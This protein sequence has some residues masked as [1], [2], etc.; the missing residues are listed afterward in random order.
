MFCSK[1][2]LMTAV[3]LTA[4]ATM[5]PTVSS[6][7]MITANDLHD[8]FIGNGAN[9]NGTIVVGDKVFDFNGL[10]STFSSVGSGG[11]TGPTDSQIF[12]SGEFANTSAPGIVFQSAFW[13]VSNGGGIDT[14]FSFNVSA[15][16]KLIDD[17]ALNLNTFGVRNGGAIQIAETIRDGSTVVGSLLASNLTPTDH[18]FFTDLHQSLLV[19]KDV[20]L[21]SIS[22]DAGNSQAFISDFDQ[23]FSEQPEP[24]GVILMGL[25]VLGMVGYRWRRRGK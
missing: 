15:P 25:G 19:S 10:E 12:A 7:G 2:F 11:A 21:T 22:T 6:A 4:L 9:G 3:A 5:F 20:G 17:A 16:G 24:S 8:L 18:T 14:K 1:K 13:S 23:R